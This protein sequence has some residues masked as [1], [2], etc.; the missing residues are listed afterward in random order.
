[1]QG[2]STQ[3]AQVSNPLLLTQQVTNPQLG[4][5]SLKSTPQQPGQAEEPFELNRGQRPQ[6]IPQHPI[7]EYIFNVSV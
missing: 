3:S 1:M 6:S 4:C 7:V 2:K 5:L